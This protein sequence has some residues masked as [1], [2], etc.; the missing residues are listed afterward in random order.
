MPCGR[1]GF[2]TG[3]VQIN[4]Q[5]LHELEFLLPR[6]LHDHFPDTHD[7]FV[8]QMHL[9][10]KPS[11]SAPAARHEALGHMDRHPAAALRAMAGKMAG[12]WGRPG[13]ASLRLACPC[14]AKA[15]ILRSLPVACRWQAS[16]KLA[17]P[18]KRA[19]S[20]ATKHEARAATDNGHRDL[21]SRINHG[22]LV[23]SVLKNATSDPNVSP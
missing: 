11:Y 8:S 16:L 5:R 7:H 1:I 12:M 13:T 23:D 14:E 6:Q 22:V 2:C 18:A 10:I 20:T 4:P 9:R 21:P 17:V 15:R 3:L 19:C